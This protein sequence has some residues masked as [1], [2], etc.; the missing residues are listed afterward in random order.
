MHMAASQHLRDYRSLPLFRPDASVGLLNFINPYPGPSRGHDFWERVLRPHPVSTVG[1][2]EAIRIKLGI[3]QDRPQGHFR[4]LYTW[5]KAAGYP[6][7]EIDG[8]VWSGGPILTPST[9][10]VRPAV[11]FE[12]DDPYGRILEQLNAINGAVAEIKREI[13]A[14]R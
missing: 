14:R 1:E 12:G 8:R 4:W 10:V 9:P 2:L 13:A 6:F 3:L 5:I 11:A 7:I